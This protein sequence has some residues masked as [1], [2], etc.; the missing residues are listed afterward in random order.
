MTSIFS[1]IFSRIAKLTGLIFHQS[2]S[3]VKGGAA[4]VR[5]NQIG[6]FCGGY[7]VT[8]F[9]AYLKRHP[10]VSDELNHA[11]YLQQLIC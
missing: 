10:A 4:N 1:P 6:H 7:S 9:R 8:S 2:A 5:I 3:Y 11:L